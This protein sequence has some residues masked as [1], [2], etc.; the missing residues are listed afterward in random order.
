MRVTFVGVGEAFDETLANTSLLAES[1]TGS[2][3]LDCGFSA[4]PSFWALAERPL[5]LDGVYLSHF[6]ADHWFGLPALLVRSLEEGR[7]RP[8]TVLGQPGVEAKVRSL[9]ELAYAGTLGKAKF[10]LRFTECEPGRAVELAGFRLSFAP[11]AHSV[12]CLAV[13]VERGD[14]SLFYS[15]DGPPTEET[16]ALATGC[17]LAVQEAFSL[18]PVKPAHGT[19]DASLAFARETGAGMLALVHVNRRVRREEHGTILARLDKIS[20]CKMCLPEPGE[21]IP[22]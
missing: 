14:A 2:I 10:D 18:D 11:C 1:D 17:S 22:L 6:H 15:G 7:T 12:P 13:R 21:R 16:R 4:A 19:L 20:F 9:M 8:L 3:L 5:E